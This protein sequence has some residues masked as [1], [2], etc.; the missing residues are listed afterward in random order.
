MRWGGNVTHLVCVSEPCRAFLLAADQCY[1][2]TAASTKSFPYVEVAFGP[3]G[4]LRALECGPG[5]SANTMRER[6][7]VPEGTVL[8]Y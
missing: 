4:V 7:V 6:L 3:A 8:Q 1:P 5:S 2:F